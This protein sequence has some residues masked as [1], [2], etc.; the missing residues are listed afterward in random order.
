MSGDELSFTPLG[1]PQWFIGFCTTRI[2]AERFGVV[3][4]PTSHPGKR[5]GGGL[6]FIGTL[7]VSES[8]GVSKSL[9]FIP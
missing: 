2:H 7:G 4:N 3:Q 6:L 1:L 5:G 8:P 9:R